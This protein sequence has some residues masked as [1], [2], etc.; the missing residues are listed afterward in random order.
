M[1][2]RPILSRD[3]RDRL[4]MPQHNSNL[5]MELGPQGHPTP[6]SVGTP[7]TARSFTFTVRD[8]ERNVVKLIL[9]K[10]MI[11]SVNIKASIG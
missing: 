3:I 5:Y 1:G 10:P 8:S 11:S 6:A 9:S 4:V 2:P 7:F